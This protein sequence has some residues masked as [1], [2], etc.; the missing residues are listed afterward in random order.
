MAEEEKKK[1]NVVVPFPKRK[2]DELVPYFEFDPDPS[3]DK[4]QFFE[5]FWP[6]YLQEHSK[7]ETR[8]WHFRGTS[9]GYGV[10][11]V[12][13]YNALQ[14]GNMWWALGVLG[15]LVPG[16]ACAWY[17]HKKHEKNTPTTFTYPL[18][19]LRGDLKMHKLTIKD[20]LGFEG[21]LEGELQKYNIQPRRD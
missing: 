7:P 13:I 19:S 2:K 4:F 9:T 8:D 17:S 6:F 3:K 21:G 1:D 16:Y 12:S 5:D 14:T 10:L 20:T 15:A 11:G 18:W